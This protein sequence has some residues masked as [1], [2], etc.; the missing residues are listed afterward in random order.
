MNSSRRWLII[1]AIIIGAVAVIAV[2]LVLFTQGKNVTL[3]AEN[4]PQG[5]VQRYLIALQDKDYQKAYD[6]LSHDT[7]GTITYN[8]WIMQN[9]QMTTGQSGWRATLEQTTQNGNDA[10]VNVTIDTSYPNGMMNNSVYSQQIN[11][12]LSKINNS[13]LIV[14]PTNIYWI[15]Y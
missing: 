5:T 6:Y 14:S 8:D 1:F 10:T 4:T 15:Y 9:G 11:F 12:L 7:P 13:W 3:L 2:S